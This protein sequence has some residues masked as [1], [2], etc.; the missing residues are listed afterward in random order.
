MPDDE[1]KRDKDV[2]LRDLKKLQH[3]LEVEERKIC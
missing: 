1:T 3:K 2:D